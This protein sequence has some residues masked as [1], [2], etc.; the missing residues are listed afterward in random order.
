MRGAGSHLQQHGGGR[1][2]LSLNAVVPQVLQQRS[3]Q[4]R[5]EVNSV[6]PQIGPNS[7]DGVV[8]HRSRPKPVAETGRCVAITISKLDYE[9]TSFVCLS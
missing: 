8:R 4:I 3:A 9:R 1:K 6:A 5:A 7:C 2:R